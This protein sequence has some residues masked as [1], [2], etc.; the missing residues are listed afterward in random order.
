MLV[1]ALA[2]Q[3]VWLTVRDIAWGLVGEKSETDAGGGIEIA[4]Q[5]PRFKVPISLPCGH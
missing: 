5:G 4:E 2:L 3:F 1:A